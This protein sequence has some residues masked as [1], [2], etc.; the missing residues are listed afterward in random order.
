VKPVIELLEPSVYR[1]SYTATLKGVH[2]IQVTFAGEQIPKS[3][4]SV[5]ISL[6]L[7]PGE[8]WA[9]G[10]GLEPEGLLVK[11]PAEFV[12]HTENAGSAK[13]EVKCVGP[14]GV[15]EPVNVTDN[16]DGTF[17]CSYMPRKPGQY[18]VTI[19][20]G[21]VASSK[22]PYRVNV[23]VPPDPSKVR[24]TGPGVQSGNMVGDS[25]Y[26]DIITTDAGTAAVDCQIEHQVL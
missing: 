1:V 25:T 20:F 26:F 19:V 8:V 22:S 18:L 23:D 3:P 9:E 14:S 5:E 12:V 4:Y 6:P 16:K 17:S 2:K 15:H 11:K 21:G 13:L 10:A 24:L 7:N